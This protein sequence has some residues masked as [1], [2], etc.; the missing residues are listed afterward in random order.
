MH[1]RCE[2]VS[3]QGMPWV[4]S[5]ICLADACVCRCTTVHAHTS[6]ARAHHRLHWS[7]SQQGRQCSWKHPS[8]L[9]TTNHINPIVCCTAAR[10]DGSAR[11]PPSCLGSSWDVLPC[12]SVGYLQPLHAAC[13]L[14]CIVSRPLPCLSHKSP[15]PFLC[16]PFPSH[17]QAQPTASRS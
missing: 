17:R 2:Q 10:P 6:V 16:S 1:S 15:S 14:H 5:Q 9:R 12:P 13:A 8:L 11:T 4:P 3:P 7:R